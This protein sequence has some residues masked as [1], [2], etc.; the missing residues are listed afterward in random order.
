MLE[1]RFFAILGGL[2]LILIIFRAFKPLLIILA[3]VSVIL[4]IAKLLN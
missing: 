4:I 2:I 3:V 1:G